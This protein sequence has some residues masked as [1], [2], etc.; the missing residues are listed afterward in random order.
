MTKLLEKAFEEAAQLPESE[1][2]SFAEWLLAELRS[3]Q[4]WADTF[5]RSSGQLVRLAERARR[6]HAAGETKN[7]DPEAL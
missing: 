2:D 1:Q 7:L 3:E 4:K 6:E 5:S